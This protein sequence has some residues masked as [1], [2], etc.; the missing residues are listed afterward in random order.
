MSSLKKLLSILEKYQTDAVYNYAVPAV[1]NCFNY[2]GE[3]MVR[4]PKG[5][6]IVNPH[7][8]YASAIKDFILP[9]ANAKKNYARPLSKIQGVTKK[10]INETDGYVGG[11]WIKKATLYSTMIRT[12]TSWD[13]DRTGVLNDENIYDLKD[14]GTFVKMIAFLPTLKKMG[15]NTVYMLPIS[16]FSLKDKKGELGSPYGV[17]SFVELDPNLKDPITKDEMTVEEEFHA[18]IE[19]CHML[20]MRV[21]IDIIPRTNSVNSDLVATNPDWFYWIKHEDLEGYFPPAVPGLGSTLVPKPEFLPNVYQSE[22]VW[23]HINKFVVNP[24][25]AMPK[26]WDKVVKMWEEGKGEILDL[27]RSE[28]GLTIAPAFSDHIND[29]QP[30]WTDVTF[31]RMYMDHPKE[32]KQFLGDQAKSIAPYILF[33]TIKSNMYQGDVINEGL[34]DTLADIIPHFQRDFG[35]DGARI[36]M[37][38]ALPKALTEKII[39]TAR[40]NDPDFCFIAEELL[41][42]KAWDAQEFGYNMIIGRGFFM[43]PRVWEYKTHEFFYASKDLPIPVFA[44]GETH[45]TPRLAAR[46]G[47]RVLSQMLSILNMFMPNGVPFINS[48]QEVWETQPMNTGLDCREN[49]AYMLDPEDPYNGKLALFD[50]YEVHYTNKD[51]WS[52]IDTLSEISKIREQYIDTLIDKNN[53]VGLGFE[54]MRHQAIGL[55]YIEKDKRGQ[56]TDN[57]LLVVANTHLYDEQNLYVNIGELRY[58]S[59]NNSRLGKLLYSQH[60]WPR[61]IKEFDQDGNLHLFLKPGEVKIIKL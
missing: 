45:D 25:E 59:G 54:S 58:Q 51:H 18:F 53:F 46:E 48:G 6:I 16:K 60:E 12:S 19:A 44:G 26:K 33:D 20:E 37:G 31:F 38:H 11:D 52:L 15:I 7:K 49:E 10:S 47:G 28:L 57:V 43:Q 55:G 3:E 29:V 1:W 39:K 8:F 50:K 23:Q 61:E 21:M 4:V 30:P 9:Q 41:P 32:S 22:S 5:E 34:W 56:Q 24:K 2:D 14:T 35:I 17:S 36:D 40:K 13:H 42:E 27:V